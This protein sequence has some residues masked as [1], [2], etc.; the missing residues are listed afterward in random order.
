MYGSSWIWLSAK[1]AAHWYYLEYQ[2]FNLPAVAIA[3]E[4]EC[5]ARK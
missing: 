4:T 5:S 3:T 1:A 2:L